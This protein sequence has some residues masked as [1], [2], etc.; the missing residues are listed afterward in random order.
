VADQS[1]N[2]GNESIY[3]ATGQYAKHQ[4]NE[5]LRVLFIGKSN[6]VASQMAEAI[7]QSLANPHFLFS[8][9]G[10]APTSV[11]SKVVEF[12]KDKGIDMSHARSRAVQQVPNLES[13]Q[14]FIALTPEATEAF[15]PANART[16]NLEWSAVDAAERA[17]DLEE[18]YRV[19]Q[20]QITDLVQALLGERDK[21]H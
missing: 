19:L 5:T 17:D 10:L 11:D 18:I 6:A 8:S 1:K 14:V 7:G 4:Q 21:A 3:V 15:P 12:M 2:I 16:V 9:A 13:Y 20:T